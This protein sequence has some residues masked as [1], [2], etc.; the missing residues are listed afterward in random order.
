MSNYIISLAIIAALT[1]SL[2]VE[3]TSWWI[4]SMA[5][6][7][8]IGH[9]VSRTNIYLYGGRFFALVF[10]SLISLLI[11]LNIETKFI[12]YLISASFL[13]AAILHIM[14]FKSTKFIVL[15]SV[16]LTKV[17]FL[18]SPNISAIGSRETERD[19]LKFY[20]AV[21]SF[22][23]GLGLGLPYVIAALFPEFRLTISNLG[24]ILNATG[25]LMLIFFVD[26]I[27]YRA[28]D[29]GVLAGRLMDYSMGRAQGFFAASIFFGI[30]SFVG[31]GRG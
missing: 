9:Y 1:F 2:L 4:K 18:E 19:K 26:Q 21:S 25:M 14:V 10:M 23:F 6:N 16:F 20:T 29:R 24:Q 5:Q 12:I 30:F 17:L 11:E 3:T 7:N 15:V 8:T 22:F 13:F 27:L 28:L 31:V